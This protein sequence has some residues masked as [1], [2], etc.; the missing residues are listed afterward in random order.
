MVMVLT[1]SFQIPD[2]RNEKQSDRIKLDIDLTCTNGILPEQLGIGDVRIA[3]M[4]TP[5]SIELINI[6]CVSGTISQ[7]YDQN[8]QWRLLSGFSL[9]SASLVSAKNLKAM[10]RLFI[11]QNSRHQVA[12]GAS[13]KRIDAIDSVEAIPT[14]RLIGRTIYRGYEVHLKLRGDHF[15]SPGDLY[16]FSSVLD[17]F[18]GGYV[19]QSCFVR[20]VVKEI[21]K[22]FRFEWPARM[23]DRCVL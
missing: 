19:T 3:A 23:G 9:N 20:L 15:T 12:V 6:K 14:D 7:S 16:L 10:L 8:R 21:G 1:P 17:R 5:E 22:G 11:N 13:D 4:A 2:H 18:L